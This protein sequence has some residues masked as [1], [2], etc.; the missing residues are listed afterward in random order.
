M[1]AYTKP[2]PADQPTL[3]EIAK[4]GV[5][6]GKPWDPATMDPAMKSAIQQGIDDAQ[7]KIA[8]VVGATK[9][10]SKLFGT[11]E[12]IGTD[13]M[14]RTAGVVIGIYGNVTQ[15]AVYQTWPADTDGKP[16]DTSANKYTITY[17]VG[18][19]PEA[20]YFWSITMYTLPDRL[21]A[22]NAINRYS[23]GSQTP[24]LKNNADGSLTIYVQH[25]SPGKDK[26]ANWLPGPNGPF[27]A[28]QR[29]YGPGETERN[30]TWKAPSIV[31]VQ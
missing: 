31:R 21:L 22:A 15:Q 29:V 2:N 4:I 27:F 28:V 5:G 16:L 26:E 20:K 9:D 1:L 13:Y 12:L 10:G 7:K 3:D 25:D 17:P 8:E 11:R 24:G 23:I 14:S 19:M 30:G 18:G 6:P